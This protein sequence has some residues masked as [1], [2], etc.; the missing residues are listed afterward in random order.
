MKIYRIDL[1]GRNTPI[2]CTQ[3]DVL[4][5]SEATNRGMKLVLIRQSMINPASIGS[6]SRAWDA[7]ESQLDPIDEELNLKLGS[8][9]EPRR[10]QD[11]NL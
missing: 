3:E 2:Y 8:R 7:S 9:K 5:I 6:I 4:K 1:M 11:R 10:I